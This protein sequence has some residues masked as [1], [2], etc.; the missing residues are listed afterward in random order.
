MILR[1]AQIHRNRNGECG[2]LP[3]RTLSN[4]RAEL[5]SAGVVANAGMSL[6]AS[7]RSPRH[8]KPGGTVFV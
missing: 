7:V 6:C 1:G 2:L 3:N 4:N 5:L 8:L